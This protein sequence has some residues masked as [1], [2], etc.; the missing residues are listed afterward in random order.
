MGTALSSLAH[1]LLPLP[2]R[3]Y[4]DDEVLDTLT[5]LLLHGLAGRDAVG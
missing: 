4:T 3:A 2:E 5:D 1:A